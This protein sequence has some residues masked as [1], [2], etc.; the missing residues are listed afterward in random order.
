MS[1]KIPTQRPI[2][3]AMAYSLG[4]LLNDRAGNTRTRILGIYLILL[5]F[6]LAAWLWA[7]LAFHDHPALLGM[8]FLAY[9]LGLRH[10]VDADHIAAIDN[11]TRKLMQ[12][13]KRPVAVG[14]MFSLGHSTVVV[15]GAAAMAATTRLLQQHMEAFQSIGTAIGTVISS[16]FPLRH[17]HGQPDRAPLHLPH[18]CPRAPW[19]AIC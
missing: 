11:V 5:I 18:L 14:F 8:A 13:G 15:L 3:I 2:I 1:Q 19:R 9:S 4:N 17:R 10:A 6:N 7:V 12:E 16:L